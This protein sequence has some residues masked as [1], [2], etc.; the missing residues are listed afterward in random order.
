MSCSRPQYGG[1][2]FRTPDP[3]DCD[4]TRMVADGLLSTPAIHQ[5][6]QQVT[7][8]YSPSDCDVTR[9]VADGLLSTPAIQHKYISTADRKIFSI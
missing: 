4:I 7:G 1:G 5:T 8:I 9:T 3:S 2:R 6:Y